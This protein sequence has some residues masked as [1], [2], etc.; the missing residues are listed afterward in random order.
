MLRKEESNA[1]DFPRVL[2][3]NTA[4]E[5]QVSVDRIFPLLVF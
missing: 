5:K 4:D 3:F 1:Q 2:N